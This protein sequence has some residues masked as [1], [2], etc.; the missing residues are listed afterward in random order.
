MTVTTKPSPVGDDGPKQVPPNVPA[1][2]SD[3]TTSISSFPLGSS[4]PTVPV[5]VESVEQLPDP[6]TN[7]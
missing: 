4:D 7:E 5:M 1:G 2:H 3:G 6:D